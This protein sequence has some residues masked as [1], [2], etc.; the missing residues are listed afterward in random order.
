MVCA[1]LPTRMAFNVSGGNRRCNE[2]DFL[3]SQTTGKMNEAPTLK[4]SQT[5]WKA[6]IEMED[7]DIDL[8]GIPEITAAQLS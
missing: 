6:L 5:N 3:F 2:K 1:T 8:S 7:D 4:D